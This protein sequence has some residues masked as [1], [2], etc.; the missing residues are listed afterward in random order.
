MTY[1]ER[2]ALLKAAGKKGKAGKYGYAGDSGPFL[3]AVERGFETTV[4]VATGSPRGWRKLLRWV[5][6]RP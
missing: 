2:K 4:E 5:G 6:V 1:A 3:S